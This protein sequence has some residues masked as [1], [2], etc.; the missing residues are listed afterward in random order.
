M[1]EKQPNQN[2]ANQTP[3]KDMIDSFETTI[4]EKNKLIIKIQRD[5]ENTAKIRAKAETE[6]DNLKLEKQAALDRAERAEA[7]YLQKQEIQAR[8][9]TALKNKLVYDKTFKAIESNNQGLDWENDLSIYKPD[10]EFKRKVN[11]VPFRLGRLLDKV[12]YEVVNEERFEEALE[13]ENACKDFT[14][15]LLEQTADKV[16]IDLEVAIPQLVCNDQN[17]TENNLIEKDQEF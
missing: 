13:S 1:N 4:A 15:N 9:L 10:N 7:R 11:A 17:F 14:K 5:L 8:Y 3:T 12:Y 2:Q 16:N 6:I